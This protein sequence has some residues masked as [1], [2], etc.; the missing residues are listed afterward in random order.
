VM[1]RL[2]SDVRF[3]KKRGVHVR[4]A[5]HREVVRRGFCRGLASNQATPGLVAF[6]DN[7]GG[8]FLVLGLARE[9]KRV[10]WLSIRDLVDPIECCTLI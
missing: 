2:S 9:G 8:I 7:L 10:L 3:A 6:V 4:G 5:L 1:L